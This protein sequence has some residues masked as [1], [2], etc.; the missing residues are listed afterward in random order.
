MIEQKEGLN[1]IVNFIKDNLFAWVALFGLIFIGIL[2][3]LI[4]AKT[5][6]IFLKILLGMLLVF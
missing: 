2:I 3:N 5:Q 1:T 4:W 6:P